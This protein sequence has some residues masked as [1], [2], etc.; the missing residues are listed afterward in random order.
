MVLPF[1]LD[2]RPL[3]G[4]SDL[5]ENQATEKLMV[6]I[7]IT[8]IALPQL[9]LILFIAGS[10]DLLG[11]WNQTDSAMSTLLVLFLLSPIATL[12][13]LVTEAVRLCKAD[14][15]K[16]KKAA[17]LLLAS[18]VFIEALAVDLYLLSQIRMH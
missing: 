18:I 6:F 13:L 9:L 3:Y 8:T 4:Q 12:A 15:G 11:G 7:R 5:V 14:T 2:Y 17:Y 1:Y 10:H 16:K